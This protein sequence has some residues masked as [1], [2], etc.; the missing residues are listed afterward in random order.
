M[1]KIN[2]ARSRSLALGYVRVST[3]DQVLEGASIDAQRAALSGEAMRRG[4]DLE[5]IADEGLSAKTL[6]R[7]G[8]LNALARLDGGD[9]DVLLAVRLDRLSRSVADFAGLLS[10]AKKRGWR[11]V[12]LSPNLDTEDAAGK[13]TAHVLA[14]AAE[15]ERDLIAARTREGM[16]Q[17]RAEGIHLG[18]PRV[19]GDEVVSRVVRERAAGKTLRAIAEGL[20]GDS[21]PTA[22][23]AVGWSTSSVQG[24]LSSCAGRRIREGS[25]A[26][27]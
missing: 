10:R 5:V 7:P 9:A 2:N 11:L 24:V 22:R 23:G 15:Y 12:L 6:S 16:A 17:R 18:R 26:T 8:L 3:D 21:V 25:A 13:F 27:T 14:A 4:W 1:P 20:T 19:L